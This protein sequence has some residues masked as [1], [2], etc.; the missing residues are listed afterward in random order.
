MD[1]KEKNKENIG[2]QD[3]ISR[4]HA[5]Q[6]MGYAAFASS[7]MFLLLNNPT[8]VYASSELPPDPEDGRTKSGAFGSDSQD[9]N[10]MSDDPWKQDDDPW[11]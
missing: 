10:N 3:T 9:G 2:A 8:K 4:R 1:N 7:T 6:K 11:K 5:L